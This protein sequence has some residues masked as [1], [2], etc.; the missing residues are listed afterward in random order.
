MA[1]RLKKIKV[2]E[3]SLV[4]RPA[5]AKEFLLY[6][7]EDGAQEAPVVSEEIIKEE[8]PI[9]EAPSEIVKE[10][11]V[12]EVAEVE[13]GKKEKKPKPVKKEE[14]PVAEEPVVEKAEVIT[15][16]MEL[17]KQLEESRIQKEALMKELE[18]FKKQAEIMKE[19][20][21]T[22]EYIAKAAV[23][24]KFVPTVSAANF[25]PVLKAASKKLEKSEFDAIYTALKAANEFI[26]KNSQLTKELGVGG[27]DLSGEPAAQLDA[28]AK[29]LVQK[30]TSITYAKAYTLACEQHPEIYAQHVRNAR[31]Q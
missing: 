21:I 26:G 23:D 11:P 19:A 27:E 31:R 12:V 6:K 15:K 24:M 16:E 3:V 13:K 29:Q 30:D 4:T 9:T 25:G 22:K 7:S 20:E 18:E 1:T 10:E 8:Q 17:E 5:I 14:E 28:L 2:N